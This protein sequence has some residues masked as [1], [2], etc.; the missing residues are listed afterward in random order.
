[1]IGFLRRLVRLRWAL[2]LAALLGFVYGCQDARAQAGCPTTPTTTGACDEGEAYVYALGELENWRA[3]AGAANPG[4]DSRISVPNPQCTGFYRCFRVE[5]EGS[6]YPPGDPRNWT[7]IR[8]VYWNPS[9]PCSAR[10]S[11]PGWMGPGL[12]NACVKGCTY[13]TEI[14]IGNPDHAVGLF[15]TGPV[16]AEGETAVEEQEPDPCAADPN[17]PGCGEEPEEPEP[18]TSEGTGGANT[19][20][21]QFPGGGGNPGGSG[22]PGAGQGGGAGTEGQICGGPNQP[23]C[24]MTL[25]D[26]TLGT[27]CN[28]P[29]TC[30]GDPVSCGILFTTWRTA[31]NG[32]EQPEWTKV[33]G[34]GT[35]GAGPEPEEGP[36]RTVAFD[37]ASRLDQSGFGGG[38]CPSLGTVN[39]QI[40]PL[41]HSINFDSLPWWCELL[42]WTRMFN[43]LLGAFLSISIILGWNR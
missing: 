4:V 2:A 39:F 28:T 15:P 26:A 34:D 33:Q 9:A 18:D 11:I 40:G 29:P 41:G 30:A 36:V 42:D 17:A 5:Y 38:T 10:A 23:P 20:G 35:E 6:M 43:L 7:L 37:P 1:V 19:G 25:G 24:N 16:C 13:A 3:T 8:T 21:G 22:H 14:L 27:G 31:C 32:G 12:G